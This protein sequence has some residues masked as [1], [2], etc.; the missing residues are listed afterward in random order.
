[1]RY[2]SNSLRYA[3]MR[4]RGPRGRWVILDRGTFVTP[5]H[6]LVV[7]TCPFPPA[8]ATHTPA[9]G[10]LCPT[11]RLAHKYSPTSRCCSRVHI[12]SCRCT[13]CR[14][15]RRGHVSTHPHQHPHTHGASP[16][17]QQHALAGLHQLLTP[18]LSAAAESMP[19]ATAS[20][21]PSSPPLAAAESTRHTRRLRREC[22]LCSRHE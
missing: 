10:R 19:I 20:S 3:G 12:C 16:H 6:A 22:S 4:I 5:S 9:F 15:R 14:V 8:S 2:G 1:M 18:P 17:I 13:K 7:P 21:A 11:R